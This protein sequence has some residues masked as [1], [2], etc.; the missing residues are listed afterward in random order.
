MENH[1]FLSGVNA[2]PGGATSPPTE[3]ALFLHSRNLLLDTN[4]AGGGHLRACIDHS[5]T[6]FDSL[7][8]SEQ[9]NEIVLV[10]LEPKVVLPSNYKPQI[11][12]TYRAIIS[13]GGDPENSTNPIPWPQ[14]WPSKEFWNIPSELR[15][16]R[17]ITVSSNKFSF[18]KT[19]LYSLRREVIAALP[20]VDFAGRDWLEP[21]PRTVVRVSRQLLYCVLNFQSIDFKGFF[22]LIVKKDHFIGAPSDKVKSMSAYQYALV[23]ENDPSYMSEKLF[24]ALFAGCIPIY[25]GPKV[26]RFK[27]PNNLVVQAE[28]TLESISEAI[29]NA[30]AI[31]QGEWRHRVNAFLSSDETKEIWSHLFVY[32]KLLKLIQKL[33]S[34][35]D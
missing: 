28:Q 22:N 6:L 27:I 33:S 2:Y 12:K 13:V 11:I 23:I 10:R 16:E 26:S 9:R 4:P 15:K 14:V 34:R 21:L 20:K 18:V 35:K 32:D 30:Q 19:Q 29:Q 24:D 31:D 8:N 5:W 17:V 7:R 25:V 3:F 1:V